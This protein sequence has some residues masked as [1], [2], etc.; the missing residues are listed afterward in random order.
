MPRRLE[1]LSVSHLP[2][3]SNHT[4]VIRPKSVYVTSIHRRSETILHLELLN[5]SAIGDT[6]HQSPGFYITPNTSSQHST[7]ILFTEHPLF[8]SLTSYRS[9]SSYIHLDMYFCYRK[10]L[11]FVEV[12]DTLTFT[13]APLCALVP[14]F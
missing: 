7:A 5:D 4:S 11:L 8:F 6:G 12:M 1:T 3:T 13:S 14:R 9:L 2:I 10:L